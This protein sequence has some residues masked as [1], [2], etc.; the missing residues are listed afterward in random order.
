MADVVIGEIATVGEMKKH[1]SSGQYASAYLLF[2]EEIY[3]KDLYLK[4]LKKALS[5]GEINVVNFTGEVNIR[6]IE[7][8]ISGLS[9]FGE[10]KLIIIRD[11]GFFKKSGETGFLE[12]LYG[13][14]TSVVFTESEVDRR[15]STFKAFLKLGVVFE[16][17]TAEGSD[18][19][20]LL[21]SEAKSAGRVLTPDAADV[22]INGLGSDITNLMSELEK[23]ILTVPEGGKIE[24]KHVRSVCSLSL[25]A[26][27]FDLTDAVSRHDTA[28]ALKMLHAIVDGNENDRGFV[29]G[30]LSMISRNW[31]NLLRSKLMLADGMRENDIQRATGQ[32]AYPVK[33]QCE[34]CRR[35]TAAEL[36]E[37]LK[38]TMELDQAIKTGNIGGMLALELAVAG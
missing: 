14:G 38:Y 33:K 37:K 4:R 24:E 20:K 16:C 9:L 18:I 17:K 27:I 23:L 7:D 3:L 19:K 22:M 32:K 35:F 31:E 1:L 6:D 29:L 15:T 34:Q 8:E 21:A 13:T 30:V 26:R 10:K 28:G 25:N 11:S 5:D 12:G 36:E 2:G